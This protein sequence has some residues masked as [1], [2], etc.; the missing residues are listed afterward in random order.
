[1]DRASGTNTAVRGAK[2]FRT[3]SNAETASAEVALTVGG[4]YLTDI[5]KVG[6]GLLMSAM[7]TWRRR[8]GEEL[9]R[10]DRFAYGYVFA[11]ALAIV[12]FQFAS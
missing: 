3:D 8:R 2:G 9:L 4:K 12:R 6:P 5:P 11:L 7:G 1:M 10:I